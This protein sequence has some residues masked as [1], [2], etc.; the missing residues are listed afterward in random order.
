MKQTL[1]IS[2]VFSVLIQGSLVLVTERWDWKESLSLSRNPWAFPL[3]MRGQLLD[4]YAM[5][6]GWLWLRWASGST[7]MEVNP[8]IGWNTHKIYHWK[9]HGR[10][11]QPSGDEA[12]GFPTVVGMPLMRWMDFVPVSRNTT[13]S[14][15]AAAAQQHFAGATAPCQPGD[16]FHAWIALCQVCGKKRKVVW[17]D[18]TPVLSWSLSTST[19]YLLVVKSTELYR[20]K[21]SNLL[22]LWQKSL[23]TCQTNSVT[24]AVD[25]TV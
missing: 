8:G 5:T 4:D 18:S 22:G 7:K 1:A 25:F 19:G 23:R 16:C 11:C 21:I 2:W 17:S 15:A 13:T 12:P 14:V 3:S 20:A 10:S 24:Q 6:M 9:T